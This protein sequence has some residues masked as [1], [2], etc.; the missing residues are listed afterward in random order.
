MKRPEPRQFI[1]EN[2]RLQPAQSVPEILLYTAQAGSGLWRLLGR[3]ND[4]P[5]YWAYQWAGGA[6]LARH[7][8]AR[9]EIV[10]GRR[11]V[12]LGTGSGLVGVAAMKSG[13]R[14][15]VAVDVDPVAIV[16]AGLN[17]EANGV[18]LEFRCADILEE[19]PPV[20]AIVLVGDLFYAA[21]LATRA[22]AFLSRCHA[23]GIEVLIGDPQRK[24]LPTDRLVLV[25]EYAVADF[26]D[27]L[28][29]ERPKSGVYA[30]GL[31]DEE[32]KNTGQAAN[33]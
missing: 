31:M 23:A 10:A 9:P 16:A 28:G 22:L 14:H 26:G 3:D 17:A 33:S 19:E 13:A 11:V 4:V 30:L 27:A 2:L 8:L 21:E 5:P 24:D 1:K 20:A 32:P 18:T 15:V 6:V 29:G 12:D 7:I 25:A